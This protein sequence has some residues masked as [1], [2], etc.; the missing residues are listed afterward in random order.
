MNFTF[1]LLIVGQVGSKKMGR[2]SLDE[3]SSL[4]G[5]YGASSGCKN[6]KGFLKPEDRT[7]RLF[8]NVGKKLLLILLAA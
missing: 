1:Y 7:V 8:R 3:G 5:Y 4:L 6:P 2:K